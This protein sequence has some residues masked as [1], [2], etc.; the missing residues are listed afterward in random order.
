MMGVT[1]I[2]IV[3]VATATGSPSAAGVHRHRRL[4]HRRHTKT[5]LAIIR[6]LR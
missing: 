2:G 6:Q 4:P 1:K 5:L 3:I